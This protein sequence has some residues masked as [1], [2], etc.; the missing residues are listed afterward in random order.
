MCSYI[1]VTSR[2]EMCSYICVTSRLDMCSYIC[3]PRYLTGV[4]HYLSDVQTLVIRPILISPCCGR[5]IGP[6]KYGFNYY[7]TRISIDS[8]YNTAGTL[9]NIFMLILQRV[10]MSVLYNHGLLYTY[11]V[12][13]MDV[14][15]CPSN[16]TDEAGAYSLF[17]KRFREV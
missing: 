4:I 11:T 1:C 7:T 12:R 6:A 3:E 17:W 16:N 10:C 8:S 13:S 15:H 9:F 14:A 5:S 2:L